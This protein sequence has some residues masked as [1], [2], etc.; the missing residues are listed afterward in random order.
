[1]KKIEQIY[2][3]EAA[4]ASAGSTLTSPHQGIDNFK[5]I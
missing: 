4:Y 5:N 2:E 3:D 1:M